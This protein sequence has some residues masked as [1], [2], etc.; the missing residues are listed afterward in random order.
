MAWDAAPD[1]ETYAII[2]AAMEVHGDLGPGFVEAAYQRALA[3][4]LGARRI[5]FAL[6]VPLPVRYKGM[7]LGVPFRVDV[8]CYGSVLVELKARP[9]VGAA[10]RAQVRHYLKAAGL[11]RG[12]LLNFGLPSLSAERIGPPAHVANL[13][14]PAQIA[15]SHEG[16]R[17]R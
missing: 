6:E 15:A 14:H 16:P 5:P 11:Q 8:L 3:I 7:D 12:L 9:M 13:G 1:P 10:E 17:H 4:E 2:G